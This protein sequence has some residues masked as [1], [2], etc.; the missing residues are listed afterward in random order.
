MNVTGTPGPLPA[1]NATGTIPMTAAMGA[2]AAMTIM[3][4]RSA[5]R[6]GGS[7]GCSPLRQEIGLG[8]ADSIKSIEITWPATGQT[9][10]L[11]GLPMQRFYKIIEDNPTAIPLNIP[12]FPL[13]TT[14]RN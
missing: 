7:F 4:K 2:A 3:T 12:T 9:Q 1:A 13:P 8:K 14:K 10:R 5:P 6:L 11:P